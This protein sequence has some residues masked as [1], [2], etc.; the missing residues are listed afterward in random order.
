LPDLNIDHAQAKSFRFPLP[1]VTGVDS[2]IAEMD[3]GP[4]EFIRIP[5]YAWA[6]RNIINSLIGNLGPFSI[7][8][9][10]GLAQFHS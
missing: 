2:I 5:K 1:V 9:A 7:S 10:A 8:F 6:A 4:I 3:G